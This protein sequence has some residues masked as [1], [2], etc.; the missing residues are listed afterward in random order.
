LSLDLDNVLLE[1]LDYNQKLQYEGENDVNVVTPP[2]LRH[3]VKKLRVD[4]L[5]TFHEPYGGEHNLLP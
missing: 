2:R 5:E 3:H 4:W 1:I